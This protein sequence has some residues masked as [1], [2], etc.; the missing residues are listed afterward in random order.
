MKTFSTIL[1]SA[2]ALALSAQS[3][4]MELNKENPFV[5]LDAQTAR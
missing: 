5:R 2:A 3:Y 4:K 1:I